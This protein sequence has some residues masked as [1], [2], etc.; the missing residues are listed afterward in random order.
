M[1]YEL[2]GLDCPSCAAKIEGEIKKLKGLSDITVNLQLKPL[3]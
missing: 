3:T 2:Q 1:R